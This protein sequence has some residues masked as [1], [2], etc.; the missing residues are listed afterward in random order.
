MILPDHSGGVALGT[1][2]VNE[3][4]RIGRV[5]NIMIRA[6]AG[7]GWISAGEHA[8]ACGRAYGGG[9]ISVVEPRALAGQVVKKWCRVERVPLS[10]AHV[11]ALLVCHDDDHVHFSAH[12][13]PYLWCVESWM[14]NIS[15]E[16]LR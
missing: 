9:G 14:Y 3:I 4:H 6:D 7:G 15:E 10:C 16:E 5:V 12:G 11:R 1:Y 13:V 8:D 2:D